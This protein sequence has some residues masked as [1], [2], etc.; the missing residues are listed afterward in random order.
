[1]CNTLTYFGNKPQ[2]VYNTYEVPAPKEQ[3]FFGFFTESAAAALFL[4]IHI[5]YILRYTCK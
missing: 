1:M 5:E 4:K 2:T 3:N